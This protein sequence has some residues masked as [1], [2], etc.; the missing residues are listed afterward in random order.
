MKTEAFFNVARRYGESSAQALVEYHVENGGVSRYRKF[1]Y[2]LQEILGRRGDASELGEL[3]EA[4]AREVK[5]GLLSC[6][7]AEGLSSLRDMTKDANWMVVSGGD[8]SELREVFIERKLFSLFNA[9][10]FG[11]PEKKETILAREGTSGNLKSPS[12]F[13]GDSRY[14]F[15]AAK[16]YDMEFVFVSDWSEFGGW[17]DYF[18]SEKVYSVN[19]LAD[20]LPE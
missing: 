10:I 11:S 14:D 17:E 6:S 2:L 19:R 13:F 7:V 20:L 3:L 15:E 8:Q 4:F 16:M 1:E 18:A 5:N 12:I 9:G